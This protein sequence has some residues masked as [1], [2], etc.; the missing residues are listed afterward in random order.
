MIY[1]YYQGHYMV[2]DNSEIVTSMFRR[3]SYITKINNILE[4]KTNACYPFLGQKG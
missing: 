4:Q 3:S 1:N 2:K